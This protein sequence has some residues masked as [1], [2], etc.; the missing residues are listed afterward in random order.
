MLIMEEAL[1]PYFLF[2]LESA[3]LGLTESPA[4][5]QQEVSA[6]KKWDR[7]CEAT[8]FFREILMWIDGVGSVVI[9]GI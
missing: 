8:T 1:A 7:L 2:P 6:I 3:V 4:S 5:I 9:G